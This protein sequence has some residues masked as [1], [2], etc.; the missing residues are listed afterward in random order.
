MNK[1]GRVSSHCLL[2]VEPPQTPFNG[3]TIGP[4]VLLLRSP[5]NSTQEVLLCKLSAGWGDSFLNMSSLSPFFGEVSSAV[6]V[7]D[8]VLKNDLSNGVCFYDMPIFPRRQ[9]DV[10]AD[11]VSYLN[12]FLPGSNTSVVDTLLMSS[13][14]NN[15]GLPASGVTAGIFLSGMLAN[16]LARTS[17]SGQLY[18]TPKTVFNPYMNSTTF[19]GESWVSCKAN[20]FSL[21]ANESKYWTKLEVETTVEG[22]SYSTRGTAPK[23]AI[24]FLLLYCILELTHFTYAG[25]SGISSTS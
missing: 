22:Y 10:N 12:P 5:N 18:G 8:S 20:V 17:F 16:G 3:S 13:I 1:S 15:P 11:W 25:I 21:P 2:W 7:P 6:K 14:D 19:E 4:V 23:I 9:I 24:V